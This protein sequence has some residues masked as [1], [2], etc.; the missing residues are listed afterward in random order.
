M[1]V[2][3]IDE[4]TARRYWPNRDPIG[5]RFRFGQ[6]AGTPWLTIVGIIKDIKHDGLDTNGIPH[7]YVSVYQQVGRTISL[8]L[9]T[10]LSPSVLGARIADEVHTVDPGLP[11]FAVRSMSEVMERSLAPRRFSAELVGA[12]AALALL[13]ASVGIYG[14]LAYLVEQRAQEIGVRI[15]L[16][17]QRGD[18]LKLI[19]GQGALLAGVGVCAGLVLAVISAPAIASLLYGIRAIDPAVFLAAPL[20]LVMVSF[21]ASYIPARRATNVNPIVALREG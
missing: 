11:L 13:L 10:P 20:I 16:G 17:A 9:R 19:L 1:Q 6:V 3:I 18:I 12:F 4:T 2:A 21:A 5:R 14:L 7:I 8:V 15:A